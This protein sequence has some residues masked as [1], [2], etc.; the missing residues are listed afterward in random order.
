MSVG[1]RDDHFHLRFCVFSTMYDSV[2][3]YPVSSDNVEEL[4]AI[5]RILGNAIIEFC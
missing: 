4:R 2:M 3:F 1:G 5:C